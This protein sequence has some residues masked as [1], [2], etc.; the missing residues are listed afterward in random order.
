L[1]KGRDPLVVYIKQYK[2]RTRTHPLFDL[3]RYIKAHPR[4]LNYPNGPVAHYLEVGAAKGFRPNAWYQPDPEAEPRGLADWLVAQR[5]E[6]LERRAPA[7]PSWGPGYDTDAADRYLTAHPGTAPPAADGR[8]LV[9]L[10]LFDT[11][12]DSALERTV[13]SLQAQ[14][15]ASWELV[16]L[17][18][19]S[20]ARPVVGD[21]RVRAVS[22]R[23]G[24]ERAARGLVLD[25]AQGAYLGWLT[26]GD[27][28]EPEHLRLL[29]A[30]LHD[31]G[32]PLGHAIA[33]DVADEGAARFA[34]LPMTSSHLRAG[35]RPE[36]SAT[37]ISTDA[38][39]AAGG[40]DATLPNAQVH[41]LVLRVALE[42][43]IAHVPVLGVRVDR[44]V[45][46]E[47]ASGDRLDRPWVDHRRVSTWHDVA[48][49]RSLIK[50]DALET[51]DM[52]A[53]LVSV[54]IP[55]FHDW[56]MTTRAVELLLKEADRT[57]DDIE[58]VVVD[59]GGDLT[60]AS[61]LV[62]L[63][64]QHDRVRLVA[65]SINHGFALGNNIGVGH[66]RGDVI[67]FLN[68][69]T[70]VRRG[71]LG[72]LRSAIASPDTLAAQALLVFPD[73]TIQSA[74]I[75]FPETGGVPHPLLQGHPQEDAEGIEHL[76]FHALTA[77]AVVVR[78]RDFVAL[79]GFDPV[80]RN[81]LEDVDLGLRLKKLR[82]GRLVVVPQSVV[83]HHESQTPTRLDKASDNRKIFLDRWAGDHP[84]GDVA[85]WAACGF[86]VASRTILDR[87]HADRRLIEPMPV[88]LRR[89]PDH[90]GIDERVPALRWAIKNP[91]PANDSAE[92]WGDTHFARA[93]AVALR[94]LGQEVII[95]H[96]PAFHRATGHFDDVTLLL[97]GLVPFRPAYGQV[98]LLWLISHPE[99][100][101]KAEVQ[102]YDRAFAASPTWAARKSAQWGVRIDPLL[103][104]TDPALFHPGLGSP[105]TGEQVLFV[106]NSRKVMRPMVRDAIDAG[107]PLSVFGADWGPLIPADFVK[108][109]YVPN[110]ELGAVYRS[111]GVV[112]N[113]HW[114]DMRAEGFL[115]NRLFDAVACGARVITDDVE[116]LREV[117]GP[118]VQ[119]AHDA[120]SL[121]KL[122]SS[123]DLDEVFRDDATRTEWATKFASEH[124]FTARAQALLDAALEVRAATPGLR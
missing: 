69:D 20:D 74:G 112:L 35:A 90:F 75:A 7:Q 104:A 64:T 49:N 52:V 1:G 95:D 119:V 76:D 28:V 60:T 55:T 58:V 68:N 72:P 8:P 98:N 97:R 108:G 37:L 27:V 102:L 43:G 93:V 111:A 53:G 61:A 34:S 24:E 33:E 65:N 23:S 122:A 88:L 36:L 70:E 78:T 120:E 56:Q 81:G 6:W 45:E 123:D 57:G 2:F 21:V 54:V 59:N 83:V 16:L 109:T 25:Q 18:R 22:V 73:W 3:A 63:A 41:D 51:H 30:A 80:F 89:R 103:Q 113:D 86:D 106:G 79:R 110:D 94:S 5:D 105:D 46:V 44:S 9:T 29:V 19:E 100:L 85:L 38:A 124:S 117:F 13:A 17:R 39:R 50:W 91:A 121:K 15:L 77:A 47:F 42:A 84:G 67:V 71:W 62:A 4:A 87:G 118:S 12:D 114:D 48:I 66:T 99:L 31:S 92:S 32:A 116:G 82:P 10:S 11:G 115:S 107:L 101:G 96:R 26:A 40:Y 14:S